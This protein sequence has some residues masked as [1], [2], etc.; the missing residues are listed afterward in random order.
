MHQRRLKYVSTAETWWTF[1][2]IC[3]NKLLADYSLTTTNFVRTP[4]RFDPTS[5]YGKLTSNFFRT[6]CELTAHHIRSNDKFI[7]Y[8]EQNWVRT[9][10]EQ[11]TTNYQSTSINFHLITINNFF[12]CLTLTQRNYGRITNKVRTNFDLSTILLA[13]SFDRFSNWHRSKPSS[14]W[15]RTMTWLVW[16]STSLRTHYDST[17]AW[18]RINHKLIT[19][20]LQTNFDPTTSRL[21]TMYEIFRNETRTNFDMSTTQPQTQNERSDNWYRTYYAPTTNYYQVSCWL[22]HPTP[23]WLHESYETPHNFELGQTI[24]RVHSKSVTS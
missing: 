15:Q 13:S 3:K 10:Y 4:N 11:I 5:N 6:N 9:H 12:L 21:K 17:A 23:Y 18:Q 14:R 1:H 24:F 20:S 16:T 2:E 7:T 22:G 8:R 19:N